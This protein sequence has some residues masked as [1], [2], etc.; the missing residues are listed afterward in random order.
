MREFKDIGQFVRYLS[1]L[2]AAE[3][4]ALQD[5]LRKSAEALAQAANA[6]LAGSDQADAAGGAHDR[7]VVQI[8]GLQA[9]IGSDSEALL[10]RELGAPGTSPQPVLAQIASRQIDAIGKT[11]VQAAEQGLLAG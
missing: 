10:Q 1:K 6:E 4:Q 3:Q 7:F 5:G 2:A 8:A 11:L 9:C